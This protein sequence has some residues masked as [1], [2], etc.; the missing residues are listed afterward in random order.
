MYIGVRIFSSV[1]YPQSLSQVSVEYLILI[2]LHIQRNVL[3]VFRF[4]FSGQVA[5]VQVVVVTS[6]I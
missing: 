5:P 4:G 6:Y 1:V 3:T 2:P